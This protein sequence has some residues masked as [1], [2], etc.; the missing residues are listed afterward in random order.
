MNDNF[1]NIK[2]DRIDL[3]NTYF[4]SYPESLLITFSE[5]NDLDLGEFISQVSN[6]VI[7]NKALDV[8]SIRLNFYYTSFSGPAGDLHPESFIKF[9]AMAEYLEDVMSMFPNIQIELA[10]RGV[11]RKQ[12]YSILFLNLPYIMSDY[13]IDEGLIIKRKNPET[14]IGSDEREPLNFL[15]DKYRSFT[16]TELDEAS[17]L[18]LE[19]L[20]I[21]KILNK[22]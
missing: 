19:L 5:K 10:F 18:V 6:F 13:I 2:P 8:I 7:D 16:G 21:E 12:L 4:K 1:K 11:I 15:L 14:P 22:I 17:E 3:E 20:I 9:A